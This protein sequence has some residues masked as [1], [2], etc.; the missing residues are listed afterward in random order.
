[1]TNRDYYSYLKT[2][3][4][5]SFDVVYFDPMFRQPIDSSS[6]LKP[7]RY[8]ADNRPLTLE[9]LSYARIVARERVVIK[10]THG[11]GEFKRLGIDTIVGGKYSS[12]SYGVIDTKDK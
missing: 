5:K 10:E 4:A 6:N 12:I 2:L 3:G 8:L 9:A 7:I 11:S 1:V